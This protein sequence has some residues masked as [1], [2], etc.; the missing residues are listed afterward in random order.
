MASGN[1][2]FQLTSAPAVGK[3]ALPFATSPPRQHQQRQHVAQEERAV[4]ADQLRRM[5][6]EQWGKRHEVDKNAIKEFNKENVRHPNGQGGV[7]YKIK[8]KLKSWIQ[9]DHPEIELENTASYEPKTP[10]SGETDS[11]TASPAP[12]EP[13]IPPPVPI[14]A[15]PPPPPKP[16]GPPPP[17]SS[18]VAKKKLKQLHWARIPG[19]FNAMYMGID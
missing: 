13:Q 1:I 3:G 2:Q 12:T 7:A 10:A 15:P 17:P 6:K 4:A 9:P 19:M 14:G 16:P 5:S 18:R 8:T 11:T